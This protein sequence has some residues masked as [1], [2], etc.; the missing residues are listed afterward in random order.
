MVRF[1]TEMLNRPENLEG[2]ADLPGRWIDAVNDWQP[3]KSITLDMDSSD[4]RLHAAQ[5]GAMWNGHLQSKCLHPL[6]VFNQY[7]DLQRCAL[8]PGNLHSGRC[9]KIQCWRDAPTTYGPRSSEGDSA[10]TQPLPSRRCSICSRP[11]DYAVRIKDNPKLYAQIDWLMKR[12]VGR[13]P[14]QAVCEHT[15]FHY[16]AKS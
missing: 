9:P 14:N 8:R 1:E 5:E 11:W 3:P 6:F 15:S 7:G 4:S 12:R 10:A 2:L 13:P 16:R